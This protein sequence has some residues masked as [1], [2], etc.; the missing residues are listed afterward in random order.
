MAKADK[1]S[2]SKKTATEAKSAVVQPK[3]EL[4]PL[5]TKNGKRGW[6]RLCS[7]TDPTNWVRMF[8]DIVKEHGAPLDQK[9]AHMEVAKRGGLSSAAKAA[10]AEAKVVEEKKI[11]GMTD[12]QK[13]AYA[14]EKR[15]ARAAVRDAKKKV[16]RDALI[17]EIKAE[18]AAGNL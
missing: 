1:K 6:V 4:P 2:K 8:V 3:G 11:A 18:I 7:T 17:A 15:L 13:L 10:K 5:L 16:E 12:E 9:G 14:A